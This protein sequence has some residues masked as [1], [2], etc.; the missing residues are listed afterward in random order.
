MLDIMSQGYI[1]QKK[2]CREEKGSQNVNHLLAKADFRSPS[3][4]FLEKML[5]FNFCCCIF[6]IRKWIIISAPPP[7]IPPSSFHLLPLPPTRPLQS[8]PHFLPNPHQQGGIGVYWCNF[9]TIRKIKIV[10]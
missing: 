5:V 9:R 7:T 4:R 3:S 8:P 10:K 6:G 1:E 2:P